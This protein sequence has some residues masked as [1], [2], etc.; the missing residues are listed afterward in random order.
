MDVVMVDSQFEL[1]A[2]THESVATPQ[3][4]KSLGSNALTLTLFRRWRLS[5][6]LARIVT[7]NDMPT[8]P[9][10]SFKKKRARLTTSSMRQVVKPREDEDATKRLTDVQRWA[11]ITSNMDEFPVSPA[12]IYDLAVS[13]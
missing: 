2:A 6:Q 7:G 13:T 8:P 9:S 12:P 11:L 3:E 4:K 5:V 1:H 10:T